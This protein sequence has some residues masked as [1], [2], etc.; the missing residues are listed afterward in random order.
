M[1][2]QARV[3]RTF[4]QESFTATEGEKTF[5]RYKLLIPI[6]AVLVGVVYLVVTYWD[7]LE[8]GAS[9]AITTGYGLLLAAFFSALPPVLCYVQN[10]SKKRQQMKLQNLEHFPV[11]STIFFKTAI[12]SIDTTKLVVD[13]DYALPMFLNFL[14][15]LVGFITIFVGYM[16]PEYFEDSTVLLGGFNPPADAAALILYQRETF[17]VV[18]MAFVGSYVYT[19]SRLLDRINNNDLYPISLHYYTAR[20]II[21]CAAA[22]VIRHSILV[23]SGN[24]GDVLQDKLSLDGSQ[25]LLLVGFVIGF[26]PDLF[27]VAMMRKAFQ[28]IKVWGV[29]N[30][31]QGSE[32][33]RSLP[34]LMID[35]LT[36][37]KIDRLNELGIDS[38]QV[39]A[40]QNPLLLLPRLPFDLALLVDWISQSQLYVLVRDIGKM[41]VLRENFV[42][43][44][45]DLHIRLSNEAARKDVCAALGISAETGAAL[46]EQLDDDPSFLRL[47]EL[48]TALKPAKA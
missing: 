19:L 34:L 20:I 5:V 11:G 24:F 27:I 47:R 25:L 1:N 2:S 30:D 12:T 46:I 31:P 21:A 37:E 43:N 17:C 36:R 45:L 15:T 35:D 4:G 16:H 26:T 3:V 44:I 28:I 38:A 32:L 9:K 6:L 18:A 23:F 39:L 41:M 7:E 8:K 14:L 33:P 29:R 22:V 48:Q 10:V 13:A 40:R 42:R